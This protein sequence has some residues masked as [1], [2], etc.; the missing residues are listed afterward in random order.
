[1]AI[2]HLPY[3]DARHS[4]LSSS[5]LTSEYQAL[6]VM[7]EKC[8]SIAHFLHQLASGCRNCMHSTGRNHRNIWDLPRRGDGIKHTGVKCRSSPWRL[9]QS[10]LFR[11][12]HRSEW[13]HLQRWFFLYLFLSQSDLSSLYKITGLLWSVT[14]FGYH[15]FEEFMKLLRTPNYL[16]SFIFKPRE[17]G[18]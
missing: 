16:N 8:A 12:Q 2:R 5:G 14:S 9:T 18:L 7:A 1:M 10:S 15:L 13:I 6:G 3:E 17:G 4:P 11:K